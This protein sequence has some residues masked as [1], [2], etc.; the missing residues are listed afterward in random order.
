MTSGNVVPM[1]TTVAPMMIS[2]TWNRSAMPV[3]PSTNQS[4]PLISSTRPRANSS[5]GMS[6]RK[7]TP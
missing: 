7:T 3:A 2:G 6:I 5:I 4:P 1:E